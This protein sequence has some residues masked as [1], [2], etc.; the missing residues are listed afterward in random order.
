VLW[1]SR[2]ATLRFG[3]ALGVVTLALCGPLMLASLAPRAGLTAYATGWSNNNAPYAW[4]SYGFY[5]LFGEGRGE[6]LLR[7]GVAAL[8]A[9]VA[10]A[11][12]LRPL[13]T[14]QDLIWR[15]TIVAAVVFYLAPAQFP[16]YAAWFLPLAAAAGS[17]PLS[18]AAVGLP[19]YFLFFPL[20]EIGMRSFHGHWLAF[21]HL[22]P[23][24]AAA[25]LVRGMRARVAQVRE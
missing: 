17:L 1:P 3:I 9:V 18:A 15:A 6:L 23:V 2:P 8:S 21:L 4:I 5:L 11:V 14:M 13:A 12:A 22:V 16:W 24:A 19:I 10:I 7:A 25:L 20:A